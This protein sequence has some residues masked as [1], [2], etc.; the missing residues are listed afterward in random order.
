MLT[1]GVLIAIVIAIG[2]YLSP[3]TR[4]VF[5]AVQ[6]GVDVSTTNYTTISS[7][8][9]ISNGGIFT[10]A[11]R[12]AALNQATTTVCAIQGPNATTSTSASL[13]LSV[14]STTASTVTIAVGATAFATTTFLTSQAVSANAQ[15][16]VLAMATSSTNWVVPPLNWVVFGMSGGVGTFSPTGV[17]QA[18][19][20]VLQ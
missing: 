5:G 12:T 1:I 15:A 17:C 19:F 8:N 14:S 10:T 11:A 13:L 6:S 16:T 3:Q 2:A 9:G 18:T 20:T 7:A 4:A